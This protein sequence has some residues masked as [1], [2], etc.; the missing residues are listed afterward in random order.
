MESLMNSIHDYWSDRAKGY[1]EYNRD[2]LNDSRYIS[3]KETLK[4]AISENFPNKTP[5]E[6]QILDAGSG[7]GFFTKLLSECGYK[8]TALDCTEAMIEEAKINVG[9]YAESV[10]WVLGNVEETEFEDMYFDVVVSRNVTW[11]LRHP[12]KA[13]REWF[14]ILEQDGMLLNFDAN[15]YTYLYDEEK[16]QEFEEDRNRSCEEGIY[17]CNVG[18]NFLKMEEIAREVPLTKVLRPAW[19][20]YILEII[21]FSQVET[22]ANIWQVVWSEE[23]KISCASTPM[24]MI[25]AKKGDIKNRVVNYWTKRSE[26]FLEQRRKELH[27]DIAKRWI[28][29]I[30]KNIDGDKP[31]KILDIGCG[32]GFFTI[33]LSKEGHNCTGIDLTPEMLNNARLLAAEEKQNCEFKL[34]DAEN[35]DFADESFDVVISRNL[36]WTLPHTQ[37]AYQEWIRVLKKD[38]ILLNFDAN[39]GVDRTEKSKELPHDHAHNTVTR[40]MAVENEAITKLLP[41]SFHSRPAWDIS[42]LQEC[43]VSSVSVDFKISSKIYLTKDIFYN[44]TP[45]FYIA[46][47]K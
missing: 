46:A 7:P 41:I 23:E 17:D 19:D 6:I 30:N 10:N 21:G 45:I 32:A 25:K 35:L 5:E 1:S 4:N 14:R 43:G 15:W 42:I 28:N 24:F 3:W 9:E 26:S 47:R 2:E 18:E 33:L 36:T 22:D 8:V 11:N 16:R 38:G 44:P 34:M 39:Y 37:K 20:S 12:E 40:E 13:Y 31:L 29:E 27:D